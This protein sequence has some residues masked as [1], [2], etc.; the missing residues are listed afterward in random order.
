MSELLQTSDINLGVVQPPTEERAESAQA[1]AVAAAAEAIAA[2][3]AAEVA[4]EAA[5]TAAA[6]VEVASAAAAKAASRANEVAAHAAIAAVA[7]AAETAMRNS[8][9]AT[10]TAEV[11]ATGYTID[12]N[13]AAAEAAATRA[14]TVQAAAA[15]AALA[16][17]KIAVAVA[18]SAAASA[19][20]AIEAAT[21]VQLQLSISADAA[22][23]AIELAH[24]THAYSSPSV[25]IEIPAQL[26]YELH[27]LAAPVAMDI[28]PNAK[29]DVRQ[30]I[31][32]A[33]AAAVQPGRDSVTE[34]RLEQ[35]R[36]EVFST[37][38]ANRSNGSGENVLLRILERVTARMNADE[39]S[40][41]S[42]PVEGPY[43][44][45][46]FSNTSGVDPLA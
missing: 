22:A 16:V 14:A 42:I 36:R 12:E 32:I 25:S 40:G 11:A 31:G 8:V 20:A 35:S 7:A 34:A 27:A 6:A 43:F 28:L 26:L 38:A 2:D 1:A 46:P 15:A 45:Q 10:L 4:F 33:P 18:E 5:A 39:L 17:A 37:L 13:L 30:V 23:G 44:D 19:A 9:Q 24:P 41:R 29:S 3:A 21:L